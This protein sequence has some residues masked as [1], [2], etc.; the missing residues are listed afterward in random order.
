MIYVYQHQRS[1]EIIEK[2]VKKPPVEKKAA[3]D[4]STNNLWKLVRQYC[5][6]Y[7]LGHI[8]NIDSAGA[9]QYTDKS[10]LKD[11]PI[12]YR[13][14]VKAY[15]TNQNFSA[16]SDSI[17][18]RL[19]DYTGPLAPVIA[20]LKARNKAILVDWV[21]PPVQD[22]FGFT[23]ERSETGSD[24]WVRVS[25]KLKFPETFTCGD[26]PAT[27]IWAEDSVFSFL[28]TTVIE[29]KTYWYR[30]YGSD[31]TQNDG[32][33]SVPIETYTYN[34]SGPPKP[35]IVSVTQS[36]KPCG[37]QIVWTPAYDKSHLGFAVFR[38]TSKDCCYRQISPIVTDNKYI[39]DKVTAGQ[40]YWYKIQ[41]FDTDGNRSLVS[42][43]KIGVVKP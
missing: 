19:S 3:G 10:L 16:M 30:I 34:F 2:K 11:S 43:L 22:L 18:D 40:S 14:A 20:G 9:T 5:R 32:N 17:C 24:P 8:A 21:A 39:D 28:D 35:T 1:G 37:L 36:A 15:D 33:R 23:V 7:T 25:P 29:K 42:N 26:I 31:Y 4:E 27:N 13:Y 38:S 41:Y 12:C 6:P